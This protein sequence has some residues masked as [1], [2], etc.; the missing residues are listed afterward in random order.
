MVCLQFKNEK[1]NMILLYS[2]L[3]THV[4]QFYYI[5]AKHDRSV[6][7]HLDGFPFVNKNFN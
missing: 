3:V 1:Y 7:R 6:E 5:P 2:I 4:T